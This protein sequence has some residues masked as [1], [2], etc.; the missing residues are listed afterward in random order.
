MK[1][2]EQCKSI[3]LKTVLGALVAGLLTLIYVGFS[4]KHGGQ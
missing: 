2:S 4:I 1:Y 3:V